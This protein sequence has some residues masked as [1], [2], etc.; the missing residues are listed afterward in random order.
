MKTLIALALVLTACDKKPTA[1]AAPTPEKKPGIVTLAQLQ[2]I[3]L[4]TSPGFTAKGTWAS[5]FAN[6]DGDRMEVWKEGSAFGI[7]IH[8]IDCRLPKVQEVKDKHVLTQA[9]FAGCFQPSDAKLGKYEMRKVSGGER[10]LRAGNVLIRIN[11]Q[12]KETA[13][14]LEAYLGKLDLDA[15]ARM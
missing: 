15:I 4:P 3:K 2:T 9:A 11:K 12:E 7:S 14:D 6:E 1:E 8:F 10:T 13:A 5:A